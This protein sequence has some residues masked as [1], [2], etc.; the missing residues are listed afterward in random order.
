MQAMAF[1]AHVA[2]LLRRSFARR[3]DP[4]SE[5]RSEKCGR[6]KHHCACGSVAAS[7]SSTTTAFSC[8]HLPT[9]AIAVS[10]VPAACTLRDW[11]QHHSL[12]ITRGWRA[13]SS[14][15]HS[16]RFG[17]ATGAY[18]HVKTSS[19]SARAAKAPTIMLM[20]C[21]TTEQCGGSAPFHRFPGRCK[22]GTETMGRIALSDMADALATLATIEP[23]RPPCMFCTAVWILIS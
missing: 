21:P 11:H 12:N 13:V 14:S 10:A 3:A 15:L 9:I 23:A 18:T 7:R 8:R 16:I 6:Q 17:A 19:T 2:V 20:L 22:I 1:E 5:G 4:A